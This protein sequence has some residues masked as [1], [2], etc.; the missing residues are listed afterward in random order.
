MWVAVMGFACGGDIPPGTSEDMLVLELGGQSEPLREAL[1][2]V[3]RV[4]VITREE[5]TR[6]EEPKEETREETRDVPI[7]GCEGD[8][9]TVMVIGW[10]PGSAW[11]AGTTDALRLS[12]T[13]AHTGAPIRARQFGSERT[14]ASDPRAGSARSPRE[15]LAARTFLEEHSAT[16]LADWP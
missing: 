11:D 7:C 9:S 8:T 14:T 4:E 16:S 6:E 3:A 10:S 5:V 1:R 12:R 13:T 2:R 15:Y